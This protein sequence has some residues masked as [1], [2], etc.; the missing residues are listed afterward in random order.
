MGKD[1]YEQIP[2]S[3]KM[4]D[5]ASKASDLDV[6]ELCFEAAFFFFY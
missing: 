4:F 5:L 3:R 2:V 6:A 1:F